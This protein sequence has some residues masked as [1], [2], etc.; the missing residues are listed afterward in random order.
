M[1]VTIV[2]R[3]SKCGIDVGRIIRRIVKFAPPG[4]LEGLREIHILDTDPAEKGFARYWK[5]ESRIEL[6]V[7]DIVCWQPW[8]LKKSYLFP[9]ITVGLALGHEIHHHV[10]ARG[11]KVHSEESAQASAL[12]YIFPSFGVFKPLARLFIFIVRRLR[13]TKQA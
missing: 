13:K 10:E 12:K 9:Y 3:Y 4:S 2:E 7:K 6:F 8:L 11:C 1:N 5:R